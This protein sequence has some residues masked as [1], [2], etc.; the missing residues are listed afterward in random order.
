[1]YR[2]YTCPAE[3]MVRCCHRYGISLTVVSTVKPGSQAKS[4]SQFNHSYGSQ[5][6]DPAVHISARAAKTK[7]KE[8]INQ[9]GRFICTLRLDLSL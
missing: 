7:E 2:D 6:C 1:M 9:T 8:L 4:E 3:K 5:L